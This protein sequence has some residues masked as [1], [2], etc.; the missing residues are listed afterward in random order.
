[1]FHLLL[2]NLVHLIRVVGERVVSE[3]ELNRCADQIGNLL[4]LFAGCME[5]FEV[6][7]AAPEFNMRGFE[8]LLHIGSVPLVATFT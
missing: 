3:V 7:G 5:P 6:L 1:M 4:V 2:R 8:S